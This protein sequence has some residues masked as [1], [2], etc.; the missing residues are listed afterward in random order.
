M[1]SVPDLENTGRDRFVERVS[2]LEEI[3]ER[4]EV[5][6]GAVAVYAMDSAGSP[7]L[8]DACRGRRDVSHCTYV[9]GACYQ[10]NKPGISGKTSL[11]PVAR[12]TFL[13]VMLIPCSSS[14]SNTSTPLMFLLSS[15]TI[16]P[17]R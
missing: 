11:S 4:L 10:F 2:G 15:L 7:C 12:T 14:A 9:Y 8:L 3:G 16:L 1:K 17:L 5:S 6:F 13:A